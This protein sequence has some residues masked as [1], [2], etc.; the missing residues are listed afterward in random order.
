M[1]FLTWLQ[2]WTERSEHQ[3]KNHFA[4]AHSRVRR[5]VRMGLHGTAVLCTAVETACQNSHFLALDSLRS[6]AQA[7]VH[8][9]ACRNAAVMQA[10]C[11]LWLW[12]W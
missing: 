3:T 11:Q 4:V 2:G 12:L 6:A 5:A 8:V 10:S 1:S 7:A 9:T